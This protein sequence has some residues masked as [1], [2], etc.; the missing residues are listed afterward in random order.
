MSLVGIRS[1]SQDKEIAELRG[2]V[3][4]CTDSR[5]ECHK[6]LAT[7]KDEIARLQRSRDNRGRYAKEV[8]GGDNQ[9]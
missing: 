2:M 9:S 1:L 6:M 7:L 3:K 8:R 4:D 5:S